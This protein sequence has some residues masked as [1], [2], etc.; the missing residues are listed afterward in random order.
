MKKFILF[1]SVLTL[2]FFTGCQK[3]DIR[4]NTDDRHHCSGDH[5]GSDYEKGRN[6]NSDPNGDNNGTSRPNPITDP[7]HDEDEDDKTKR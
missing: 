7:N 6:P 5:H 3:E 2:I 4:P 1:L